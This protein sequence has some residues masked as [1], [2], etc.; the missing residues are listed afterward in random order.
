MF[1]IENITEIFDWLN[2]HID[3]WL[4]KKLGERYSWS[5]EDGVSSIWASPM[6][7]DPKTR[8]VIEKYA[9]DNQSKPYVTEWW[10]EGGLHVIN[11]EDEDRY[12][13]EHYH[14]IALD[15]AGATYDE[16]FINFA[17]N[18]WLQ[19]RGELKNKEEKRDKI[20]DGI[21]NNSGRPPFKFGCMKGQF[22]LSDDFNEEMDEY[23]RFKSEPDFGKPVKEMWE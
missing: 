14:D 10:I 4:E 19:A 21:I 13:V 12:C 7:V 3:F 20:L 22:Q 8:K 17:R 15:D 23:G 11:E 16:A 1:A 6:K 2:T 18:I 5:T 9:H